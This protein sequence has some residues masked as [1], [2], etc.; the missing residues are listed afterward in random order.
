IAAASRTTTGRRTSRPCTTCTPGG[1]VCGDPAT[2]AAE[3]ERVSVSNTT[4]GG[5]RASPVPE[6]RAGEHAAVDEQLG[7]GTVRRLVG[8]EEHGRPRHLFGTADARN[9][10]AGE[11]VRSAVGLDG[12][13]QPEV[14]AAS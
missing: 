1:A 11:V 14:V 13:G 12:R 9:G 4:R 8:R 2:M 3:L 7:T 10:Q 5:P 6:L